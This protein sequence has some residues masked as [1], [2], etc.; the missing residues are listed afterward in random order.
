MP[1]HHS[2]QPVQVVDC[3]VSV[4]IQM[5]HQLLCLIFLQGVAPLLQPLRQDI[6]DDDDEQSLCWSELGRCKPA[7]I[8][9]E[10]LYIE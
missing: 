8:Q 5:T 9:Q 4:S 2:S 6:I 1:V 7:M 3:A 10:C